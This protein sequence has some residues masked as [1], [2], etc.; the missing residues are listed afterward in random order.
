[1][2]HRFQQRL[3]VSANNLL[4]DPISDRRNTQRPRPAGRLRYVHH[5]RSLRQQH[6]LVWNP[7]LIADPEG[8]TLISHIAPH[9]HRCRCVRGTQ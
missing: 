2:E 7:L 1:M 4:A 5:H 3:Q 9:L 8:P 6:A